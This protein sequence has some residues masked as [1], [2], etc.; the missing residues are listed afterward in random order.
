[1]CTLIGSS[2]SQMAERA[3][4]LTQRREA[5]WGS[6]G[7]EHVL[8]P[9]LG[10]GPCPKGTQGFRGKTHPT[11]IIQVPGG[12]VASAPTKTLLMTLRLLPAEHST[13]FFWETILLPLLL[14]VAQARQT[15]HLRQRWA[16]DQ[17][18]KSECFIPLAIGIGIMLFPNSGQ[19]GP[20]D[21]CWNCWEHGPLQNS[22]Y[23]DN[24]GEKPRW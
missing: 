17:A 24:C 5:H 1:M 10:A 7:T 22:F 2:H 23:K 9:T 8:D 6:S 11:Q 16:Q 12:S 13:I 15:P 3:R 20:L 21:F 4:V 19:W 14:V 18:C